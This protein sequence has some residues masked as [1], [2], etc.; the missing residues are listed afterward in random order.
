MVP[1]VDLLYFRG[2][3]QTSMFGSTPSL[4]QAVLELRCLPVP[5]YFKPCEHL[6][7]FSTYP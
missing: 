7:S 1:A 4:A 2:F 3:V 6:L 5:A